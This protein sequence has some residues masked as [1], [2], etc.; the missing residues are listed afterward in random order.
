M[1]TAVN[2][3]VRNITKEAKRV[4]FLRKPTVATFSRSDKATMVTYDSGSDSNYMSEKDRLK[5][6]LPIL[7]IS[8]KR[9]GVENRAGISGKYV[10][11][12]PLPHLTKKAAEAD[13]FVD[14]PKYLISAGKTSDDG[15]VSIVTK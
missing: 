10:T 14:F 11:R 15:N 5:L 3:I 7:H 12:L 4:R 13:T 9:V 6:S 8:S 2:R 1:I